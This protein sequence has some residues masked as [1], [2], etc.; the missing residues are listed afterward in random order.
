MSMLVIILVM[1]G[2]A[3]FLVLA[4][5]E[6]NDELFEMDFTSISGTA[7]S[8][9]LMILETFG[10]S[11]F[12]G[13][14]AKSLFL[15]HSFLVVIILL[16][17]LI[18]II[19][20]SYDAVLVTSTEL[21][22]R[23]RLEVV[24]ELTTTFNVFLK[25]GL[26]AWIESVE[27]YKEKCEDLFKALLGF[28]PFQKMG[29]SSG[30]KVGQKCTAQFKGKGKF[31]PGKIAKVNSDGTVNVDLDDGDKDR[32]V[33]MSSVKLEDGNDSGSEKETEDGDLEV[34]MKVEAR[35][36]GKSKYSPSEIVRARLNGTFDIYYDDGEKELGVKKDLIKAVGGSTKVE[37]LPKKEA[38]CNFSNVMTILRV[39]FSP[40]LL[41]YAI[42]YG[43]FF[44]GPV[45]L[46]DFLFGVL[47]DEDDIDGVKVKFNQMKSRIAN[48]GGFKGDHNWSNKKSKLA[49]FLRVLFS[50]LLLVLVLLHLPFYLYYT[51]LIKTQGKTGSSSTSSE[52]DLD[53]KLDS[54]SS[55]WSGRVLDIVCR[56]NSVTSAEVNKIDARLTAREVK[57]NARMVCLREENSS[58]KEQNA[59]IVKMLSAMSKTMEGGEEVEAYGDE[60]SKFGN[61]VVKVVKGVDIKT[62]QGMFGKANPYAKLKIGSQEHQTKPH[63]QGGK[64]PVWNREF[65]FQ[66]STEK[67]MEVDIFDKEDVGSDKFMGRATVRI[68]DWI[69]MCNFHG[70][71][72]I[73][74]KADKEIGKI[75][76]NVKFDEPTEVE[77][78]NKVFGDKDGE[79]DSPPKAPPR[80]DATEGGEKPKSKW[81]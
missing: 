21:F 49:R 8:L 70:D 65:E 71:I 16:N 9:Y 56:V 54:S 5:K 40:F 43:L 17:V 19:S 3:F 35:Y 37:S 64:N 67:E 27:A 32:Y 22:W 73:L 75:N 25:S 33:D 42:G 4:W 80:K 52:V 36:R 66:I 41:C 38:I 46:C 23:S 45:T 58:I 31:Y 12:S 28:D 48:L 18:A 72:P 59:L 39:I 76:V 44:F 34:G 26:K 1:F 61:L 77:D 78:S 51:I 24:A 11:A 63:V 74:D 10:S 57:M 13:V 29:K 69:A 7:W 47:Y 15:C 55:D 6:E 60:H 50:P 30:P 2:H 68:V 81:K 53:L 20:D 62:G 79:D 14:W